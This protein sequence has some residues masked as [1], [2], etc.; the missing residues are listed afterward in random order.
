MKITLFVFLFIFYFQ[1]TFVHAQTLDSACTHLKEQFDQYHKFS[2]VY[3]DDNCGGNIFIPSVYEGD[4]DSIKINEAVTDSAFGRSCTKIFLQSVNNFSAVKYVYPNANNGVYR[5]YDLSGATTLSFYARGCGTVEFMLGGTNRAPFHNSLLPFQDGIDIRSTGYVQLTNIWHLY[6]IDLTDNRF[7][8]Y[9][10]SAAG[11]NNKYCQP[12]YM[13]TY[14]N[15][16]FNYGADDGQGNKCMRLNW[17][18]GNS[19]WAGIYFCPPEGGFSSSNGYDLTGMTK[20]RFKAKISTQG[21]VKFLFGKSGD[22]SGQIDTT[23]MLNTNWQWYEWKGPSNLNDTNVAGGFGIVVGGTLNTPNLSYTYIDSVY[24]D[25]VELAHDFSNVINGFNVSATKSFNPDS[26][27]IYADEIKYDKDRSQLPRFSQ[28]Y[29]CGSD[30]I[31]ITM[32]NRADVY[33]NA[34][35][36]IVSLML[37]NNS[38]DA[39]YLNRAKLIGDAFIY[40]LDHDRYFNDGRVRNSYMCGDINDGDSI[41]R[42][43]GWWNSSTGTW[44]EDISTVSTSTG[45]MAWAGLALTSLFEATAETQYLNAAE[46]IAN[47][48]IDSTKTNFGFTGGF[49]GFDTGQTKVTWKSTEHNIDL[50]ALFNRLH[51][52]TSIPLYDSVAQNAKSFVLAMW[53]QAGNHFWTGTDNTGITPNTTCIPLDIQAWYMMAF[54]DSSSNYCNG[55]NW[56]NQNCYLSNFISQNYLS[57]INGFDFNSDKDGIWFEGTAQAAIANSMKSNE[58]FADSLLSYIEYV[59]THHKTPA[60]YNFNNKGIVA[61][62]H[63]NTSTGFDWNYHNRLHIGATSWYVLAKLRKNPY[64]FSALPFSANEMVTPEFQLFIYPTPATDFLTIA[65]LPIKNK[66]F[67]TVYDAYGQELMKQQINNGK[68]QINTGNF[69]C[70]VYIVKWT[71][72]ANT[73][74]K[75]F[76]KE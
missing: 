29:V 74:T 50:Y 41:S 45:N 24:Y 9:L 64:Y 42:M 31:D 58:D 69:K 51:N 44:C 5:G 38:S 19:T 13:G 53:N 17:F 54:Q 73:L 66:S 16:N 3:K 8:V 32:K 27:V 35:N 52:I 49:E 26:A 72:N 60:F 6:S 28:S 67:V 55:M 1:V 30:S 59:Q 63:N 33:D 40:V 76:V 12:V 68:T 56:A 43:P 57:N 7:W 62:D 23:I 14:S 10:D 37:Y 71:D 61:A 70:G 25:G 20:I 18:G 39:D 34:L 21:K 46:A 36:L 2:Y 11:M 48:C 22:S 65:I 75:K 4:I 47:W 15:F